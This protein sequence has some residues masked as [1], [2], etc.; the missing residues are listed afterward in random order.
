MK[1]LKAALDRIKAVSI[2]LH[3]YG[4]DATRPSQSECEAMAHKLD[5]ALAAARA[6]LAGVEKAME[7]ADKLAVILDG[8]RIGAKT[9][10]YAA[11]DAYRAAR[12]TK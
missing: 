2:P 10:L 6:E 9:P 4:I 5:L 12:G 7:A 11:I 8:F 3:Q 1:A